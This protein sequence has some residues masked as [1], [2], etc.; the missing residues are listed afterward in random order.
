MPAYHRY[1]PRLLQQLNFTNALADVLPWSEHALR[2]RDLL[3]DLQNGAKSAL[4]AVATRVADA[5]SQAESAVSSAAA[6]IQSV[7]EYVPR[8][9]SLGTK[10]FCVGYKQDV[11]CSELPLNLS[12]LLPESLQE[13]PGPVQ[14]AIRDRADALSQLAESSTRFPAFSV[15]DTMISGL[16]LMA[17]VATLSLSLA[18]GRPR[19][20]TRVFGKLK[21]VPRALALLAF[22]LVCC[23]PFVLLGVILGT[24]LRAADELP[25]WV[26][27]E[28]GE[29]CGLSFA[30]LAC[31]LVLAFIFAA[32][33]SVS[34]HVQGENVKGK[35]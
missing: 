24:I 25:S 17:I 5:A 27:V 16:V 12:S 29:A 31:A 11:N 1:S 14:D 28:R 10:R 6:T 35:E 9:C 18:L 13:L 4:N 15:P 20:L 32:A 21:T 22:G 2:D 30:A 8:N 26:E 19:V 3:E 23:S 33:P 7:E 34:V